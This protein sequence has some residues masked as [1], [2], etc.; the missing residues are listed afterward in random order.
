MKKIAIAIVL[1]AVLGVAAFTFVGGTGAKPTPTPQAQL[2]PVKA[3]SRIVSE[4]KVVPVR[5]AAISFLAGGNVAKVPVA[6][7]D[8]VTAGQT[9]VELD[10]RQLEIQL[11]QA[12]ANL[13]S[14]QAKLNQL[15]NSPT[16]QE[17]AAAKQN[18][19][20]AQAAYD[21]LLHP[22][23]TDIAAVKA[24]LEKTKA[25]VDQ[26]QAAYDRVGGDGNPYANML[27]QRVQLQSAW[28]DYQKAE[29]LYNAK[30]NPTN[31]QVQQALATL[32]SGKNQLAKLQPT[33][34]DLAAAQAGVNAAQAA[35]DLAAEQLKNAK[36]VAPFAG[37]VTALDVKAGE[38]ITVGTPVVR[39]ADTSSWQVETTDLTELN[40]VGVREGA[41][42]AV[43]F[44]AIPNLELPGK[45]VRIKGYG[46]NRQ[47][48]IV[49]TVVVALDQMEERLRWNM[50]AK[51]TIEPA[52]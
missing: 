25:A 51:V 43:A 7:G 38:Y 1:V 10:T 29:L 2:A 20:S 22:S 40:V 13:A 37:V 3:P 28:I 47:G 14:A 21:N 15:K 19:V 34:D 24:D 46:E 17:V 48:D 39:L 6:Y 50:T 8:Q 35:R 4:G 45:V 18:V 42:V 36:L 41:S 31:A 12:D 23:A 16:A 49:Y 11:A 52:Q 33:A 9:L 27:P 30:V 32:E 44:D 26:A 5:S